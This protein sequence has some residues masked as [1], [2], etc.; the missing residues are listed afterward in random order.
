MRCRQLEERDRFP[1]LLLSPGSALI[2]WHVTRCRVCIHKMPL[3][4][5]VRLRLLA[6]FN[7]VPRTQSPG[8]NPCLLGKTQL[9]FE[10]NPQ[11]TCRSFSEAQFDTFK[12]TPEFPA[13]NTP[14][15]LSASPSVNQNI[16]G[17]HCIEISH[18]S[19]PNSSCGAF[20]LWRCA[21][22]RG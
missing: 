16:M 17:C 1:S 5:K 14:A 7:S 8:L 3:D 9:R 15:S 2:S 13:I 4:Y 19:S 21:C 20:H 18:K 22:H 6:N 11:H 10:T 12:C